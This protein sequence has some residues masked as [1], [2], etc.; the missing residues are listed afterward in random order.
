VN[1]IN[2]K[3]CTEKYPAL[4]KV[5]PRRPICLMAS[6]ENC[7]KGWKQALPVLYIII[8]QFSSLLTPIPSFSQEKV[9]RSLVSAQM[10]RNENCRVA[11]KQTACWRRWW[12][13]D[14]PRRS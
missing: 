3:K 13:Q 2:F 10:W 12:K 4:K 11:T 9:Y 14:G 7:R 8:S 1:K 5:K 6:A